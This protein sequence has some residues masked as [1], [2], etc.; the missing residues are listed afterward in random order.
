[1]Y[2]AEW[3]CCHDPLRF[4][5]GSD[6][7][8]PSR[9]NPLVGRPSLPLSTLSP[10]QAAAR[11]ARASASGAP[12]WGPVSRD[13]R[14]SARGSFGTRPARVRVCAADVG[15]THT[16]RTRPPHAGRALRLFSRLFAS[17]GRGGAVWVG[18]GGAGFGGLL[19]RATHKGQLA[20]GTQVA[21]VTLDT[22]QYS[23]FNYSKVVGF[24]GSMVAS[25]TLGGIDGRAPPQGW[26][27]TQTTWT[28]RM[29][30]D[31][32]TKVHK[33]KQRVDSRTGWRLDQCDH[34]SFIPGLRCST[35]PVPSMRLPALLCLCPTGIG[36]ALCV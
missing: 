28:Q 15:A 31:L 11:S 36:S 9:D 35:P 30:K 10:P 1:M 32:D 3:P 29:Q 5:L 18:R 4:S 12:S 2:A 16:P 25:L 27:A 20:K 34:R 26:S 24:G 21:T 8:S 33:T 6:D 23:K 14:R 7:L 17:G 22:G 19:D 13:A